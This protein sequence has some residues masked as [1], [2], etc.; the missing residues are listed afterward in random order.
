MLAGHSLGEISA[1]TAAK[2]LTF[3]DGLKLVKLDL[4]KCKKLVKTIN[5]QWQLFFN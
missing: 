1:L 4:K 2:V 3:E 5:Q